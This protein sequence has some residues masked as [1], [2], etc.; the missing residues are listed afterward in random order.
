MVAAA[1]ALHPEAATAGGEEA[2]I[3]TNPC[4]R[5]ATVHVAQR[6]RHNSAHEGQPPERGAQGWDDAVDCVN[7]IEDEAAQ[8]VQGQVDVMDDVQGGAHDNP[9]D[10]PGRHATSSDDGERPKARSV[11]AS[12][13]VRGTPTPPGATVPRGGMPSMYCSTV[14][15]RLRV[16]NVLLSSVR[17]LYNIVHR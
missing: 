12:A 4:V 13:G 1:D 5:G 6:E 15:V 14:G 17:L 16:L 3:S 10:T 8:D 7:I 9:A 2:A 11:A